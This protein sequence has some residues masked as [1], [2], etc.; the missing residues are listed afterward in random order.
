MAVP[1]A[2]VVLLT[3]DLR[4]HDHPALSRARSH[5]DTVAPLFV[6]DDRILGAGYAAP[7]RLRFLIDSLQDLRR[8]LRQ[9]GGE[10]FV[11]RGD[12]VDQA[13]RL[14]RE[15]HAGAVY[16][17]ADVSAYAQRRQQRLES[18]CSAAGLAFAA[19]PGVT[20]V[21]PEALEPSGGDHFKVFTPY[22]RAW[23]RTRWRPVLGAPRSLPCP[24]GLEAG[25]IP[26]LA[27]L[28]GKAP[29]PE[30]PPGGEAAGRRALSRWSRHLEGYP[31]AHDDLAADRTSR[32]SPYLHFGC[33]SP[34]QVAAGAD[35]R[36]GGDEWV[37]QLCWRDFHHQVLASFPEL[38]RRDYRPRGD[39]WSG[40]G[41]LLEAWRQGRT[42]YPIVDAGMRQLKQ[43]GWMHNRA[44]LVVA[45]FLTKDLYVD[46]RLG[47]AHFLDWLVDGDVANN[48][49]NWQWVAGTG[50]DTRPNRV[51]NPIRQAERFDPTGAYVR[52]YLP[53]LA[54]VEGRAVHQ[55]WRLD[56]ARRRQL[57][58]PAPLVDHDSAA[59]RL[60]ETR[61]R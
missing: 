50:N 61:G 45:S 58:S 21:P 46:W 37:R 42:G 53:E 18:A 34:R 9:R 60:R 13:V 40:D 2:A 7:N 5:A 33:L 36:P 39:S 51:F 57:D 6:L 27:E 54:A 30:L 26:A 22:W 44:R 11:R 35:G 12:P 15:C 17:S 1:S 52:R 14:A 16:S 43:E 28:T 20:V 41:D 25:A 47:A 3:R 56:P 8:S 4:V 23:R 24:P 29:S 10:L 32:L 38:P 31:A 59:R 48:S 55:P 19:L 49:G